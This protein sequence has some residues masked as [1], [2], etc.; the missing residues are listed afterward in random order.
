MRCLLVTVLCA[1]AAASAAPI[2]ELAQ[3]FPTLPSEM[4]ALAP[5]VPALSETIATGYILSP[6][7]LPSATLAEPEVLVP[8]MPAAVSEA[9]EPASL[10]LFATTLC[11]SLW[12][13]IRMLRPLPA[14]QHSPTEDEN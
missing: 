4:Q 3:E 9:S 10:Y 5:C 6:G 12:F 1:C 13:L 14:S 11:I 2:V 8:E 7:S